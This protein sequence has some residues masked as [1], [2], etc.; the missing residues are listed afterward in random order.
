MQKRFFSLW[1]CT[2]ITE[3]R[4]AARRI[5]TK[6]NYTAL[7]PY[8]AVLGTYRAKPTLHLFEHILLVGC[9]VHAA[10]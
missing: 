3:T 4:A 6:A 5:S 10:R 1:A 2:R 7:F 9:K 8:F